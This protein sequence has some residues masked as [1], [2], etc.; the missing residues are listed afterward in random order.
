MPPRPTGDDGSLSAAPGDRLARATVYYRTGDD[1]PFKELPLASQDG[2]VFSADV[3]ADQ[4]DGK[5]LE[6]YFTAVDAD[7]RTTTLPA[8]PHVEP[9]KSRI[10]SDDAPPSI[11]HE[12][13]TEWKAGQPLTIR[14]RVKDAD[15]VATVRVHYRTLNQTLPYEQLT[16]ER[17][18]NDYVA[19]I[20]GEAIRPDWDFVYSIEAVDEAGN[21]CFFGDWTKTAP[22]VIVK[23]VD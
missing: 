16:M 18:G 7:G 23:T 8:E 1:E 2:F 15:G 21:G 5:W 3:P 22:Y 11:E 10:T 12:P 6:Y 13:I 19:T 14:A 17:H 20:P 9:Y 4:L